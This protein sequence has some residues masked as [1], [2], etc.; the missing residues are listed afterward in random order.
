MAGTWRKSESNP[1][2]IGANAR[3]AMALN[4]QVFW[5]LSERLR[6]TAQRRHRQKTG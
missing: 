3:A 4:E 1:T 5:P 6:D 2:R